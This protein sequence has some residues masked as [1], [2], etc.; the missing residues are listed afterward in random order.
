MVQFHLNDLIN[1]V[2]KHTELKYIH[3]QAYTMP[4][5]IPGLCRIGVLTVELARTRFKFSL[6]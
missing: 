2:T 4:L 3:T 6:P 1:L 5:K